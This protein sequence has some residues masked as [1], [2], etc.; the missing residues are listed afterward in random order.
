M[1]WKIINAIG[2]PCE[3]NEWGVVRD[4]IRIESGMVVYDVV[5]QSKRMGSG[6]WGISRYE[7]GVQKHY[8]VHRLVALAFVPNPDNLRFVKFKDG[9]RDHVYMHNLEWVGRRH[10]RGGKLSRTDA[11][12]VRVWRDSGMRVKAIAEQHDVSESLVY[13]I[14]SGTR[15]G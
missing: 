13:K 14:C 2:P 1:T 6:W 11:E 12:N 9:N 4:K 5:V 10:L 7:A 8:Y 15:W 3:I